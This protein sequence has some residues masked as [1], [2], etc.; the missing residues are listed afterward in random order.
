MGPIRIFILDDRIE[1]HA[2]GRTPN[3]GDE[4]A[5]RAGVHVVR[6]PHIYARLQDRNFAN[7]KS[8]ANCRERCARRDDSN[9]NIA[10][11]ALSKNII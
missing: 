11:C 2:P 8:L 3:T 9:N 7:G 5:K 10:S 1:I 4:A 6:N